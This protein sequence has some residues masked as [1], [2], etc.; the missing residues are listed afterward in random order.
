MT[1]Q[2]KQAWG[3]VVD[4]FLQAAEIVEDQE[5]EAMNRYTEAELAK[6]ISNWLDQ[7]HTT[8]DTKKKHIIVD[9]RD[10]VWGEIPKAMTI[11]TR[12]FRD[13]TMPYLIHLATMRYGSNALEHVC[14]F[15][16]HLSIYHFTD[17][18]I[19]EIAD[20][21]IEHFVIL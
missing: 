20:F 17:V 5:R 12:T 4:T 19:E 6:N 18:Q 11:P 14:F 10:A 1:E 3:K 8:F 15:I 9:L 13:H 16:M 21:L 7:E 2:Y